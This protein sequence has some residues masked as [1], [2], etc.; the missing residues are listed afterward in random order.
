MPESD[1]PKLLNQA[2]RFVRVMNRLNDMMAEME[3]KTA[4]T[5]QAGDYHPVYDFMLDRV[6][7]MLNGTMQTSLANGDGVGMNFTKALV[8]QRMTKLVKDGNA[9]IYA[10]TV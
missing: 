1:L 3:A 6:Y 4:G 7:S 9:G 5:A 10:G 8:E 2:P